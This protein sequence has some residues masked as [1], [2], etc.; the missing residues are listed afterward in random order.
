MILR[1]PLHRLWTRELQ[2]HSS[3]VIMPC[4]R[5]LV[6]WVMLRSLGV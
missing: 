3:T 2:K 1:M 5:Q 6:S 4:L